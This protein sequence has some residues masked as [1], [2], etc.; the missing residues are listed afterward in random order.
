MAEAYGLQNSIGDASR[1]GVQSGLIANSGN[2]T[3]YG[4]AGIGTGGTTAGK[5][6]Y[7]IVAV[8]GTLVVSEFWAIVGVVPTAVA[9]VFRFWRRPNGAQANVAPGSTGDIAMTQAE[10]T[11]PLTAVTGNGYVAR[12]TN[13]NEFNPGEAFI[14]ELKAADTGA[15]ATAVLGH[16]GFYYRFNVDSIQSSGGVPKPNTNSVGRIYVV[17]S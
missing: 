1:S 9:P 3:T 4:V 10:L 14:V 7:S 8:C 6:I 13:N 17:T 12:F 11:I 5:C 16:N 2:Y 15:A